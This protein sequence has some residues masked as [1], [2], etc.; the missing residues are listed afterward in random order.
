MDGFDDDTCPSLEICG[1]TKR[2]GGFTSM[3]SFDMEVAK[4]EVRASSGRT[5]GAHR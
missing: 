2:Y 5:T 4:R 3:K 1:L